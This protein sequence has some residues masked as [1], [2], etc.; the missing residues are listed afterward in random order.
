MTAEFNLILHT[1]DSNTQI[2][3]PIG[4]GAPLTRATV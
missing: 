1:N 2:I 4:A 3:L